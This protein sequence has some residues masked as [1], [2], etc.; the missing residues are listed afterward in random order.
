[1]MNRDK[2]AETW[3]RV[4]AFIFGLALCGNTSADSGPYGVSEDGREVTD[5]RTGLIWQRCL[6]GMYW[7]ADAE[8]CTGTP[9]YVMFPEA[10][11][12]ASKVAVDENLPWRLPN[13]KEL[14]AIAARDRIFPAIQAD[15]FPATPSAQAWSGSTYTNDA[16]F[17]WAVNFSDG[18]VYYSYSEDFGTVRLVRDPVN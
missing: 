10:L 18:A 13:V 6:V 14:A 2:Q 1:M 5:K 8:I 7:N 4:L 3:L 11:Q 16:F 9:Y 15:I 12:L 17:A